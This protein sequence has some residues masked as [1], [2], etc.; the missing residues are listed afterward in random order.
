MLNRFIILI[1]YSVQTKLPL[2]GAK[3]AKTKPSVVAVAG[4]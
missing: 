4:N 1:S 2:R 3:H